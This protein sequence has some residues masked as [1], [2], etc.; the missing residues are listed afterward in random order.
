M[1]YDFSKVPKEM[2]D[3]MCWLTWHR[4]PQPDGSFKK[5]PD[6]FTRKDKKITWDNMTYMF[7]SQAK[8]KLYSPT[9]LSDGIGFAFKK[10]SIFA[11]IDID[12]AILKDGG[13]NEPVRQRI[14]PILQTA[15]RDGCYIE[16]SISGTG[17]HIFGYTY[18]KPFLLAST[19][20]SGKVNSENVEIHYANSYFTVSANV[21]QSGWGCL[22]DSIRV[23]YQI[24]NG[25]P[26]SEQLPEPEQK[27]TQTPIIKDITA[28]NNQVG[29]NVPLTDKP[30]KKQAETL[31]EGE[32]SDTDVLQLPGMSVSATLSI[33]AKDHRK[34]GAE[35]DEAL[36]TGYPNED[37]NKSD[38]DAKIIG[39]LCYWLYRYG[40]SE[41]CKV[42]EKS[43]LYRSPDTTS[44]GNNYVQY[45]VHKEYLNA[46]KFFPAVNYKRLTAEEK[47][48]LKRWVRRKERK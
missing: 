5:V 2:Q 26:L 8:Q 15:R 39:T 25:K 23:A 38:F 12:N 24:I 27:S 37:L 21:L 6:D 7:M 48:K 13:Y 29:D 18:L 44:K 20:G 9:S 22:D 36:R 47:D 46:E 3:L 42:F 1:K 43:A 33:M 40:E 28:N 16:K 32:F 14:L 17:Y 35:T 19:D 41:I 11:G 4:F 30:T 31:P 10:E 34:Y 45:T